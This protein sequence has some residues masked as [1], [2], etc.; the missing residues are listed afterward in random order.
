MHRNDADV[1]RYP[2]PDCRST[3]ILHRRE[4][5][6][7]DRER[8]SIEKAHTDIVATLS[9]HP[10]TE[11]TLQDRVHGGW[12]GLHAAVLRMLIRDARVAEDG[13]LLRLVPPHEI[14]ERIE[15]QDEPMRT[16][17]R[18]GSVPGAHDNSVFAMIAYYE[19]KGLSW[20]ETKEQVVR[21]LEETGTWDRG[22]FEEPT[23]EALV[24]DKRHV[25][26]EGYGWLEKAKAA[27]RVIDE[28]TMTAE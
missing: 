13:D 12:D 23:P 1:Y 14:A 21:W 11:A 16:I 5:R 26:A 2:C 6:F 18:K 20:E 7:G 15:P 3:N 25:H 27:K 24:A 22:G 28:A 17:F 9:D 19:A 10:V 4:C 8:A